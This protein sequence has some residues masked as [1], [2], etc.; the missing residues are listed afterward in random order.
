MSPEGTLSEKELNKDLM[1]FE[2]NVLAKE[3]S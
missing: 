1:P 3:M 2:K